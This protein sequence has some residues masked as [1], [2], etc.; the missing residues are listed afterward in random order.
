MPENVAVS[1]GNSRSETWFVG[2]WFP[3]ALQ[4]QPSGGYMPKAGSDQ[5]FRFDPSHLVGPFAANPITMPDGQPPVGKEN[6]MTLY[7]RVDLSGQPIEAEGSSLAFLLRA[8]LLPPHP[9]Q[10]SNRAVRVGSAPFHSAWRRDIERQVIIIHDRL[11][12]IIDRPLRHPCSVTHLIHGCPAIHDEFQQ[13]HGIY[14]HLSQRRTRLFLA[15]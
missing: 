3:N 10:E 13:L 15:R 12:P 9:V 4:T 14:F 11:R 5:T 7:A 8:N 1:K 6:S 2:Q